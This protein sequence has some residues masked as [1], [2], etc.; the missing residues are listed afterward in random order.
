MNREEILALYDEQERKNSE[1]PAYRREVESG[2]VRSVSKDPSRLSFIIHSQLSA[3]TANDAI[4]RQIE[5]FAT[6]GGYGFEW[7]TFAHD[8]PADLTARLL[9][10]GLE[11]DEEE[12][13][14]T[15]DLHN[16]P[17]VFLQPVTADVRRV[18]KSSQF[19]EIAVLQAKV[20]GG[21]FSW[22][23]KQLKDNIALQPDYWSIYIVYV[24]N[25]PACAAW[26]SFPK[27]S[28]FAGL[29]GGSTLEKFRKM[30]LYTAVVA[31]RAQEAVRRGYR[32]LMVDA[33][34]MSRPI[35]QKRGFQLLTHT[36]PYTWK[37]PNYKKD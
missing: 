25:E 21:N 11:A 17:P 12:S 3:E 31:T 36:T 37:N 28:R 24:N 14:L 8:E 30:G 22:L 16:C 35:L 2:V 27:N 32:F 4:Q 13:L 7:K 33:S 34:E 1:H 5:Y 19:N 20:W 15:M 6:K 18:T 10:H 26:A 23:E 9:A 29:W